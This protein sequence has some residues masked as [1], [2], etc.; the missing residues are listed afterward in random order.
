MWRMRGAWT[1]STL[2]LGAPD[3]SGMRSGGGSLGTVK[4]GRARGR[5]WKRE[6]GERAGAPMN[7]PT[8][9]GWAQL[10]RERRRERG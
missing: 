2:E 9:E 3:T 1:W 7:G 10:L 5:H 6:K 4:S 8:P